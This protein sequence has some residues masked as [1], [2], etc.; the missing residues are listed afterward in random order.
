MK[1]IVAAVFA[2]SMGAS[3]AHGA[4]ISGMGGLYQSEK[5]KNGAEKTTT[6][7]A[8]RYGLDQ[9]GDK[10]WFGELGY[11]GVKD[12]GTADGTSTTITLGGGMYYFLPKIEARFVPYLTGW[13]Q[14]ESTSAENKIAGTK[15]EI[16]GLAY[17]SDLGIRFNASDKWFVDFE[18]NLF[19]SNLQETQKDTTTVG[20]VKTTRETTRMELFGDSKGALGAMQLG[21]GMVL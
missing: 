5:E 4:E 17:G 9:E 12:A 11:T 15:S 2:L 14:I 16:S 3:V 18:T 13:A 7:L 10:M 6:S 21:L 19:A 8:A 20:G 1:R